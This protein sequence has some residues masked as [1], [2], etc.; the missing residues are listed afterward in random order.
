VVLVGKSEFYILYSISVY[1]LYLSSYNHAEII[2]HWLTECI[3]LQ[4]LH[5]TVVCALDKSSAACSSAPSSE[6]FSTV[7]LPATMS[8]TVDDIVVQS[9][10]VVNGTFSRTQ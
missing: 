3:R 4:L 1:V 8:F 2:C 5:F 9:S 10:K 7:V 6:I